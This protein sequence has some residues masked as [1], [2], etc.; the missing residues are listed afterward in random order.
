M[1]SLALFAALWGMAAIVV[2][3]ALL[4]WLIGLTH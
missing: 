3:P 4:L 2:V 1:P